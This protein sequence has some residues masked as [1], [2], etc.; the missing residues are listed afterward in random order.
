VFGEVQVDVGQVA[1]VLAP[2]KLAFAGVQSLG[3]GPALGVFQVG[4]EGLPEGGQEGSELFPDGLSGVKEVPVLEQGA[5]F[6]GKLDGVG[7]QGTCLSD[8]LGLSPRGSNNSPPLRG[9]DEVWAPK[10]SSV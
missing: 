10:G 2:G 6:V 3:S 8:L 1:V 4:Q 5:F 7:V 9:F